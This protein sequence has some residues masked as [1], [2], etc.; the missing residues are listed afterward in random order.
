MS[1]TMMPLSKLRR[2]RSS[3]GRADST[4]GHS[5]KEDEASQALK[6]AVNQGDGGQCQPGDQCD[7]S[8]YSKHQDQE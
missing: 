2:G 3:K 5:G 7:D 8:E 1:Q 4:D 6:D